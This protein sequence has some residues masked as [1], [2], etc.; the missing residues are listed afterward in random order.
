MRNARFWAYVNFDFVKITL[1]PGQTLEHL[2]GGP[3]DEG[4]CWEAN[5][6]THTG[7]R[8][9]NECTRWASDCDGRTESYQDY[10]ASLDELNCGS[11]PMDDPSIKFPSWS[12]GISSQRDYSAE[13]M[14][15]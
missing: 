13:A 2:E 1:R 7:D 6:W 14:G 9:T 8:V 5:V 15:Y 4:F 3:N 11:S 12:P 10:E